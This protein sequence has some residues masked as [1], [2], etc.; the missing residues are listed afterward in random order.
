[1]ALTKDFKETVQARVRQDP[2]FRQALLRAAVA[3]MLADDVETG[4]AILRDYIN[5]TVGFEAL[6]R[7]PAHRPRA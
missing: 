3:A 4:K 6:G 2:S 7:A 5:A 1:M